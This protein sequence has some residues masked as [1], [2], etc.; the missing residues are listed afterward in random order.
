MRARMREGPSRGLFVRERRPTMTGNLTPI[1]II[2]TAP[3]GRELRCQALRISI[4]C[5]VVLN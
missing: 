4:G 3:G 5:L 2:F 1:E